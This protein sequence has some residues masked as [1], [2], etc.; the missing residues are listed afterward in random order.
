M[1]IN[2]PQMF[3]NRPQMFINR[4]AQIPENRDFLGVQYSKI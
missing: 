3:I 2:R 1:F 4:E